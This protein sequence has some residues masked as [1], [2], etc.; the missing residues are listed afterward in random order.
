MS[1]RNRKVVTWISLIVFV[2]MSIM[3]STQ[4]AIVVNAQTAKNVSKEKAAID[5]IKSVYSDFRTIKDNDAFDKAIQE[6]VSEKAG[7]F[8]Q[9]LKDRKYIHEQDDVSF[10]TEEHLISEEYKKLKVVFEDENSA[11]LFIEA[12]YQYK[13]EYAKGSNVKAE[14][15]EDLTSGIQVFYK[16]NML[17]EN[18]IWKIKDVQS[19]DLTAGVR[20]NW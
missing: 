11:S 14:D 10:N 20:W 9:L 3:F 19:N 2:V 6:Q 5:F 7:S 4:N 17:K 18:G 8:K 1:T 12:E 16:V 15:N 13:E